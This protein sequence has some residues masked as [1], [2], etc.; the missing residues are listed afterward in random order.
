M[1]PLV[2]SSGPGER[3]GQEEG[4]AARMVR[5]RMRMVMRRRKMMMAGKPYNGIHCFKHFS[6]LTPSP[7]HHYEGGYCFHHFTDNQTK[8]QGG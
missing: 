4:G 3:E 2:V 6:S 7:Q 1:N 5:M 8:G